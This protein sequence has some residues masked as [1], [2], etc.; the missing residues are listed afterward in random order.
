MLLSWSLIFFSMFSLPFMGFRVLF[1]FSSGLMCV[2]FPTVMILVVKFFTFMRVTNYWIMCFLSLKLLPC[3]GIHL[4]RSLLF[5][6]PNSKLLT[7]IR[8]SR[9]ILGRKW[10]YVWALSL[11]FGCFCGMGIFFLHIIE[12][13]SSHFVCCA[14][15]I[16]SWYVYIAM[17]F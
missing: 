4:G 17:N 7:L 11:G 1:L 12:V 16:S 2:L 9:S 6:N 5:P 8:I 3:G 13:G 15:C 14:L 10:L